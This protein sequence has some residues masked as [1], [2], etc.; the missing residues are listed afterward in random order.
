[1]IHTSFIP[2]FF[3]QGVDQ[4][5]FFNMGSAIMYIGC[6]WLNRRG[7]F[8]VSFA[9]LAIEVVAHAGLCSVYLGK[10]GFSQAVQFL[11]MMFFL[12]PAKLWVKFCFYGLTVLSYILLVYN[13]GIH[14]PIKVLDS[15][16]AQLL[17]MST[18]FLIISIGSY[19]AY[20]V[21]A[22]IIKRPIHEP[23][24]G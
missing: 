22:T 2:L 15:E 21:F 9:A 4:L 18:S 13:D 6:L 1:V 16:V 23:T 12:H 11:P 5:G 20:F 10:V 17:T 24:G 19:I 7:Q 8:N 3:W 14:S